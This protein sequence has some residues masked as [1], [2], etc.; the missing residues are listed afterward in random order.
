MKYV[1]LFGDTKDRAK[2]W[3]SMPETQRQAAYGQINQWFDKYTGKITG[4]QE[5]QPERTATTV[6]FDNGKP[7]VMDGPFIEGKESIGGYAEVSVADLDEAIEMAKGW[8]TGGPVE[9]RPVVERPGP[10]QG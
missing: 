4:G 1:L 6:K 5:L 8:P 3:E 7:V 10:P 9:V 2:Q